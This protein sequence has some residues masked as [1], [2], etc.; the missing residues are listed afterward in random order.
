MP[1]VGAAGR[2]HGRPARP[3]RDA[4]PTVQGVEKSSADGLS[5]SRITRQRPPSVLSSRDRGGGIR[6]HTEVGFWDR[7]LCHLGYAPVHCFRAGRRGV[8]RTNGF[9]TSARDLPRSG[10]LSARET[11]KSII[12]FM[13]ARIPIARGRPGVKVQGGARALRARRVGSRAP[14]G[15][16]GTGVPG[17]PGGGTPVIGAPF[18]GPRSRGFPRPEPARRARSARVRRMPRPPSPGTRRGS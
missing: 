16:S 18:R 2:P 14:A 3:A 11:D 6:T 5:P 4:S 17:T 8:A 1:H 12:L 10:S 9:L 7:R 15:R 13:I